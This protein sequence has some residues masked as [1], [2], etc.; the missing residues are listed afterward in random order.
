MKRYEAKRLELEAWLLR[1]ESRLERMGSVATTADI[2]DAQQK[3]QKV[4]SLFWLNTFL[5]FF[6]DF[7]SFPPEQSFHTE[8][9]QYKH[10]VELFNQLTQ[11]LIA[12]YPSDDT[13]RIKRMTD[14]VNLRFGCFSILVFFF[15]VT[16]RNVGFFFYFSGMNFL[17]ILTI[18]HT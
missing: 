8:L 18:P 15:G 4:S 9:I 12:V 13:T 14:S 6:I 16:F 1:M 7:H 2:L 17:V 5:F 3:E 11:K 10:Q